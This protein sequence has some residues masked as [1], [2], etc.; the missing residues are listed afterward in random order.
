MQSPRS[1]CRWSLLWAV[2]GLALALH[3]AHD[4]AGFS[5]LSN[6]EGARVLMSLALTPANALEPWISPPLHRVLLGLALAAAG[7]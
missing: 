2:L 7:G 4:A 6:D 5:R 1:F 3:L